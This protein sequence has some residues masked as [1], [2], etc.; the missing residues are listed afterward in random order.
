MGGQG[1]RLQDATRYAPPLVRYR[2]EQCESYDRDCIFK[3]DALRAGWAACDTSGGALG[4]AYSRLHF[5]QGYP[6]LF[7]L[8]RGSDEKCR[9]VRLH[10]T[11]TDFVTVGVHAKYVANLTS[12]RF[13]VVTDN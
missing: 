4:G 2:R 3:L 10:R 1:Q 6:L 5:L 7:A 13:F 9:V 12:P 8:G 11:A